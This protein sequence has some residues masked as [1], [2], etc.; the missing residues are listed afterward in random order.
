ASEYLAI[1]TDSG[2]SPSDAAAMLNFTFAVGSAYFPEIA[3]LRAAR[4]LWNNLLEAYGADPEAN[5]AYLHAQ[6]SEWNKTLYDPYTNMLRTSAESMAAAVVGC[7]VLSVLS[8]DRHFRQPDPFSRRIARNQQL[9]LRE[10]SFIDK[11]ADP[12]AGS[13]YV[14]QLTDQIGEQAWTIF[15]NIEKEGG[16]FQAIED[17]F[18]QEAIQESRNR[19]DHAVAERE[20][21]FV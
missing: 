20:R 10:E 15:Q 11:V 7:A 14:E 9:V 21:T 12:A 4:L 18:V 8:F 13:Y 5:P 17:G 1:L 6:S 3:K 16:L 19:R 2:T